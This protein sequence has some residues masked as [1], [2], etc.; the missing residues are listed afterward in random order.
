MVTSVPIAISRSAQPYDCILPTRCRFLCES[1]DALRGT[2]TG[3][4]ELRP[5]SCEETQILPQLDFFRARPHP[6]A[7]RLCHLRGWWAQ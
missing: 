7:T 3:L 2:L 5:S 4:R 6:A 1:R